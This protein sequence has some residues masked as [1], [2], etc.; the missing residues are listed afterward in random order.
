MGCYRVALITLKITKR[1]FTNLSRDH[2][3]YHIDLDNYFLAKAKLFLKSESFQGPALINLDHYYGRLMKLVAES[4][5][6][7]VISIGKLI[8]CDFRLENQL[9]QSNGQLISVKYANRT[10]KSNLN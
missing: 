2:L 8:G 9:L 1:A 3:D 7:K 10:Y 5:G 6:L 4:N